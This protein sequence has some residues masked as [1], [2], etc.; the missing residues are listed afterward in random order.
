MI[1]VTAFPQVV[2]FHAEQGTRFFNRAE[3]YKK[4]IEAAVCAPALLL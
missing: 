1:H 3:L 2:L 4:K